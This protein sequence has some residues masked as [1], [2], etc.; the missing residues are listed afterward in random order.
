MSTTS[1]TTA[2]LIPDTT[3]AA[4]AGVS[5]ATWHRLRAAGKL[6]PAVKLG[7]SVRWRRD[8]VVQWISAG[9]PPARVWDAMTKRRK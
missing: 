1:N 7:R 5:R 8:E 3:A 9:C 4:M 6:P 2:L